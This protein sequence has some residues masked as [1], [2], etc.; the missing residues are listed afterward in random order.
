MRHSSYNMHPPSLRVPELANALVPT[1]EF[2]QLIASNTGGLAVSIYADTPEGEDEIEMLQQAGA[3]F[4]DCF[5][6]ISELS[7]NYEGITLGTDFPDDWLVFGERLTNDLIGVYKEQALKPEIHQ[8]LSELFSHDAQYRKAK[9]RLR[10]GT[11]AIDRYEKEHSAASDKLFVP[12]IREGVFTSL[13]YYEAVMH[14]ADT[15]TDAEEL[16]GAARRLIFKHSGVDQDTNEQLLA[17]LRRTEGDRYDT[18]LFRPDLFQV[19]EKKDRKEIAIKAGGVKLQDSEKTV[20]VGCPAF[21]H[22]TIG[23]ICGLIE[24]VVRPKKSDASTQTDS[25]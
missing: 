12:G 16:I 8:K 10:F 2:R 15:E 23:R 24:S 20:P 22:G 7:Q 6:E 3:I 14:L 21:A 4:G 18:L 9:R 19:Y 17:Q 11:K 13:A 5:S 1:N 25:L